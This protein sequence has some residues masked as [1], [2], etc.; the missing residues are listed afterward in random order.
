[1]GLLDGLVGQAMGQML[2]GGQQ[3]G[4]AGG[5]S[6]MLGMVTALIQQQ[7]GL[8]GLLQKFE[9]SGLGAQAASWVGTGANMPVDANQITAALGSGALGNLAAKFGISPDQVSGV[10]AQALPQAVDHLTPN[11]QV[12]QNDTLDSL[13]GTLGGLFKS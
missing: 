10:L 3:D 2:G 13:A 1:M 12:A 9:Q 6:T 11:G 7:G 8:G 4:S 5:S